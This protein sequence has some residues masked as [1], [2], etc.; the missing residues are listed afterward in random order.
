MQRIKGVCVEECVPWRLQE[1]RTSLKMTPPAHNPPIHH[2]P[3]SHMRSLEIRQRTTPPV[4][5]VALQ[6][7]QRMEK[8]TSAERVG[9]RE[10]EPDECFSMVGSVSEVNSVFLTWS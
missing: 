10:P 2:L 4:A 1:R 5:V 6:K 8:R 3:E 7:E 9:S